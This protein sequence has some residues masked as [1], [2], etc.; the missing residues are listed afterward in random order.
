MATVRPAEP[1]DMPRIM[2]FDSFPGDRIMEIIERRMLV[3]EMDGVAKGYVPWQT[4]GC[5]GKD[6]VNKL[7]I[8]DDSRRL[9]FAKLLLAGFDAVLTGRVFISAP[10]GNGAALTLLE[11]TGWVKAGEIFGLLQADE[12][13]AFFHRDIK[14]SLVADQSPLARTGRSSPFPASHAA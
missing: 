7:V 4:G 1:H 6:Y 2:A 3:V 13:E 8:D 14:S 10:V 11:T 9:G 12:A 5:I